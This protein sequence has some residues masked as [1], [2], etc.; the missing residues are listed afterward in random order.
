MS[1]NLC[2]ESAE[3]IVDEV[4]LEHLSQMESMRS[5]PSYKRSIDEEA[6]IPA[7]QREVEISIQPKEELEAQREKARAQ[8]SAYTH[9]WSDRK[10]VGSKDDEMQ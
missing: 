2:N 3:R 8:G 6:R 5:A 10:T 7:I 1:E 9:I 4:A